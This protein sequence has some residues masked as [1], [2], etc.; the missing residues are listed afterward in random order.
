MNQIN[1]IT[2]NNYLTL[3]TATKQHHRTPSF[4]TPSNSSTELIASDTAK[5]YTS[6]SLFSFVDSKEVV[7][8]PPPSNINTT[9]P[10][11]EDKDIIRIPTETRFNKIFAN[12]LKSQPNI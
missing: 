2:N 12:L 10:N 4:N 5:N 9:T 3:Q 11:N 6:G 7:Q 8:P 1:D